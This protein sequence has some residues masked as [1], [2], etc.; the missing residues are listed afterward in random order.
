VILAAPLIFSMIVSARLSGTATSILACEGPAPSSQ[1]FSGSEFK[2]EE[3]SRRPGLHPY[4]RQSVVLI[5]CYSLMVRQ[6]RAPSPFG[7]VSRHR[8]RPQPTGGEGG[9][10]MSRQHIRDGGLCGFFGAC[11]GPQVACRLGLMRLVATR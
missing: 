1:R 11:V 5:L 4:S 7:S 3:E 10:T 2:S 8:T 9:T 6:V